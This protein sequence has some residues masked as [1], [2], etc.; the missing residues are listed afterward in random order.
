MNN[1][2]INIFYSLVVISNILH[3][4]LN[5]YKINNNIFPGVYA[6]NGSGVESRGSRERV[7]NAPRAAVEC[8]I[9]RVPIIEFN[10]R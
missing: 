8:A 2:Y 3:S 9:I 10:P 6:C 4:M 7:Y 5:V 1:I